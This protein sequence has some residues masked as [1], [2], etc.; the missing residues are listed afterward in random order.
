MWRQLQKILPGVGTEDPGEE[1][2]AEWYM[3]KEKKTKNFPLFP[4]VSSSLGLCKLNWLNK[5][6]REKGVVYL[7]D[8][9]VHGRVLRGAAQ[10]GR[11][12]CMKCN[13][14]LWERQMDCLAL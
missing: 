14:F 11:G 3:E 5:S 7:C 4:C 13:R 8:E 9:H 6:Y 1:I 12:Y 2:K 10:R